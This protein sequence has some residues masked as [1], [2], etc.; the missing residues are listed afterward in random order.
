M[1]KHLK[2]VAILECDREKELLSLINYDDCSLEEIEELCAP[3]TYSCHEALYS[4][5]TA[6]LLINSHITNHPSILCNRSWYIKARQIE[7]MI[8]ELQQEIDDLH[9]ED[10]PFV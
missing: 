6:L 10:G 1:T 2:D 7:E 5:H 3:G 4:C 8:Q 9:T